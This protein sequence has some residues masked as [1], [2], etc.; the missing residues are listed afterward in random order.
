VNG[1]L[2]RSSADEPNEEY[3]SDARSHKERVWETTHVFNPEKSKNYKQVTEIS[4]NIVFA[5]P[6]E[7]KDSVSD[8]YLRFSPLSE[9]SGRYVGPFKEED[10]S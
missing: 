4:G 5:A 3:E 2:V 10:E 1:I 9:A 6:F 7:A 8:C